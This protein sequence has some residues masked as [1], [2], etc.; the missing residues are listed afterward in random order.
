MEI[1]WEK[2]KLER[3]KDRFEI[4]CCCF[5]DGRKSQELKNAGSF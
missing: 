4:G 3:E 5:D 2:Q 1:W